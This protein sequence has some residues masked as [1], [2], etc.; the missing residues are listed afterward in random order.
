MP[1]LPRAGQDQ[2]PLL[3]E[4]RSRL[5]QR[6]RGD[7]H[8]VRL[9]LLRGGAAGRHRSRERYGPAPGLRQGE[10]T[11]PA[12]RI[13]GQPADP[14]L[15]A[16]ED[17]QGLAARRH[18]QPRHRPGLHDRDAAAARH[19]DRAPCQRRLRGP[20]QPAAGQGHAARGAGA[21]RAAHQAD[22]A[23]APSQS[24]ASRGDPPGHVRRGQYRP[25]H[26]QRAALQAARVHL[27]RKDRHGT[28]QAHHRA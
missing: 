25:W 14:H 19:H 11:G 4:G 6:H 12:R 22:R 9:L 17:R 16:G 5:D 21:A 15:E 26:G 8:V 2:V 24:A 10:R 18:V 27:R 7:R 20:T 23:V 13:G 28:G 3:A 1:R